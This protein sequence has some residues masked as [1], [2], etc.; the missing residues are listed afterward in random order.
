[1]PPIDWISSQA[2]EFITFDAQKRLCVS[3]G[4]TAILNVPKTGDFTLHVGYDSV[5]QRIVLAKP[6]VV[7][8]PNVI[9]FKF[10]KRRYCHVRELVRKINVPEEELPV[11]FEYVGKDYADS[12]QGSHVFQLADY[13]APDDAG[14]A[15]K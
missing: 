14:R 5:N 12:P 15:D 11:R 9:P 4:A 7:K 2:P 10:D 6:D 3:S 1:M 13:S 8:L